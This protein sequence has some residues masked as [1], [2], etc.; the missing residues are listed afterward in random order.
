MSEA[1]TPYTVAIRQDALDDLHRRIDATRWPERE[2][3]DDWSQ[4]VPLAKL[5]EL[6]AYWRDG[7][8]WRRCETWLNGIGHFETM[9]DG[10]AIR[11]LHVRSPEPG[12]RPLVMTHGWP[13]SILEFRDCIAPLTDPVAHGGRAQDAFHLVIP[14]LPGFGFSGKPTATG[15]GVEK[16]A[17]TWGELMRRLG[18]DPGGTRK[19]ATGALP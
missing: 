14:A 5:H 8:D 3:V 19:A 7:Y 13:G 9:I 17:R 6:V 16:I 11:F 4:G 10:L 12:A 15:W 18:Y 2:A 1:I